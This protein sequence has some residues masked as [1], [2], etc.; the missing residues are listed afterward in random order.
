[1][2]LSEVQTAFM[3]AVFS[4]DA[5]SIAPHITDARGIAIYSN[6]VYAALTK[7]LR[8]IY[9]VIQ[10]LVGEPFFNFAAGHYIDRY[11]S[12]S[13][14]LNN[15]GARFAAFLGEFPSAAQLF[16]LPDVAR[17]EWYCH[18]AYL[19]ADDA[20]FDLQGLA[21]V[22]P[23]NYDEL[24]F[25]LNS[26]CHLLRSDWPIDAIWQV[27]QD[28]YGGDQTVDLDQGGVALL[29]QRIEHKVI[30][31]PLSAGEWAFLNG[32]AE[33]QSL[34]TLFEYVQE[35]DPTVDV[36]ALLQKF[37][38]QETLAAFSLSVSR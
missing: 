35:I 13:G 27:N 11:P 32:I 8:T 5:S 34:A 37:I 23:Q 12:S 16:Y 10:S 15:F 2:P 22:S 25:R 7:A 24:R 26:A 19:A 29:I 6:N 9:P 33:D 18:R 36:G 14:D 3:Q 31:L 17:L 38:A 21:T 30:M 20:T 28:G 4:K 1:M